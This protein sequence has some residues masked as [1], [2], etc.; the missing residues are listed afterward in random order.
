MRLTC[1][2]DQAQRGESR[3]IRAEEA[4]SIVFQRPKLGEIVLRAGIIDR[5]QLDAALVDS[6][7]LERGVEAAAESGI[8]PSRTADGI[9]PVLEALKIR[10]YGRLLEAIRDVEGLY[11]Q[12]DARREQAASAPRTMSE[13]APVSA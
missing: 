7:K 9:V 8:V 12:A 11:R 1:I 3:L 2:R 5:M 4:Q 6:E 10:I 13:R